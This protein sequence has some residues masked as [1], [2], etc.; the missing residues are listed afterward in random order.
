[1]VGV[2]PGNEAHAGGCQM[3]NPT[4]IGKANLWNCQEVLMGLKREGMETRSEAA[5]KYTFSR[6]GKE[7]NCYLL[8][9]H[10]S[11]EPRL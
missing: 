10:Y 3:V 7:I 2:I 5:I 6:V 4:V 8:T 1:V 9:R 11:T